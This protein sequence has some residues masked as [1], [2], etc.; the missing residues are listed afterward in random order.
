MLNQSEFLILGIVG[1]VLLL[2]GL[3][4]KS[5]FTR[6]HRPRAD[7]AGY[8][9][10]LV[11][12]FFSGV[13]ALIPVPFIS[14][15]TQDVVWRGC[16]LLMAIFLALSVIIIFAQMNH[17][18][19]RSTVATIFL[20][21]ISLI[22]L[23]IELANVFVWGAPGEYLA[24]VLWIMGVAFIQYGVAYEIS[25]KPAPPQVERKTID[26][27]YHAHLDYRMRSHQRSG[28]SHYPPN[29]YTNVHYNTYIYTRPELDSNRNT[30]TGPN[31]RRNGRSYPYTVARSNPHPRPGEHHTH[32]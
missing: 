8:T 15:D 1:F 19:A 2:F 20:L 18:G 11:F 14:L 7:I 21:V 4:F 22:F 23:T 32:H 26:Y 9:I 25:S 28:R 16:S 30:Y 27:R 3:L 10:G 13:F 29:G 6:I 24:G 17:L 31:F 12:S 5:T